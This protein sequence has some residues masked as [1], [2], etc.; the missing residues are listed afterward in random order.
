MLYDYQYGEFSSVHNIFYSF[1][2]IMVVNVKKTL[3]S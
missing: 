2:V 1:V 3:N